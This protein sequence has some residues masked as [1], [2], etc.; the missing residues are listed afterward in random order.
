MGRFAMLDLPF[1]PPCFSASPAAC[2]PTETTVACDSTSY[3]TGPEDDLGPRVVGDFHQ[4]GGEGVL[5]AEGDE[6][7]L[8]Y[9]F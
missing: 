8:I 6:G 3:V 4:P 2:P 7:F 1:G 9:D 5:V